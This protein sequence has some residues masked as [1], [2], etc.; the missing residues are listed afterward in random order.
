MLQKEKKKINE[1]QSDSLVYR[2]RDQYEQKSFFENYKNLNQI[3]YYLQYL[4]KSNPDIVSIETIGKT[5]EGRDMK[6]I[7]IETKLSNRTKP[8][9]FIDAGI[10]AREWIAVSTV[11]YIANQLVNGYYSDSNTKKLLQDFNWHI[12]PVANPD[13]YEYSHNR[14]YCLQC[15]GNNFLINLNIVFGFL[16]FLIGSNVA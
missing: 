8:I 15:N 1:S 6:V 3:Y 10:H 16:S 12:L 13:G 7:K 9:I 14:V 2:T 11:M 5:S 4:Q